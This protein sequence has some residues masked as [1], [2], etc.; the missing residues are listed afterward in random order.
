MSSDDKKE[1]QH[2]RSALS[3]IASIAATIGAPSEPFYHTIV[4][5]CTPP[6]E[7]QAQGYALSRSNHPCLSLMI[8]QEKWWTQVGACQIILELADKD[9]NQVD[10]C[11]PEIIP[12]VKQ[13]LGETKA[14]VVEHGRRG[15][16]QDHPLD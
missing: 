4:Q 13:L 10:N 2:R 7:R 12:A 11:L 8:P 6:T 5:G 3:A 14:E 16:G 15:S 1:I 9:P